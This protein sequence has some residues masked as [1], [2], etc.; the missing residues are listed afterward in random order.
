MDKYRS[1]NKKMF[2]LIEWLKSFVY[3]DKF[4]A[5]EFSFYTA[6]QHI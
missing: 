4:H 5:S 6:F 2:E 1:I 3:K